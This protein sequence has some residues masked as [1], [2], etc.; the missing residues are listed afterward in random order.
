MEPNK[1][2]NPYQAPSVDII[3]AMPT[4]DNQFIEGGRSVAAGNGLNWIGAGWSIF[5]QAPL[6]WV[7]CM[8]IMLVIALVLAFLPIIGGFIN[9]ILFALFTGGLMI[10]C[11]AQH[12]GR[13][14]EIGDLFAGFKE[15]TTSLMIVGLLYVVASLA[16]L[17]VAGILAAVVLGSTGLIGALMSGDQANIAGLIGSSLLGFMMIVLVILALYV[18][19]AMAFWFASTL[20]ALQDIT[21]MAAIRMSF[22]ACLK[23][24]MPFLV[25]GIVFL[26]IFIAAALPF[27]LGLLV[28]FPLLYASTY[29]AYRD[30]FLAE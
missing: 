3:G 15:K 21:P 25:Y 1:P 27:G 14:L 7:V 2:I 4:G 11:Q 28:A 26:V 20:V 30:I 5:I 12:L 22:S 6:H 10:G 8:V 17:V 9:Y 13:P 24:F 19:V 29:A 23:N 18:P 16:L